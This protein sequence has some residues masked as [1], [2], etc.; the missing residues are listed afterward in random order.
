M[1]SN[2]VFFTKIE[3][4]NIFH[5]NLAGN[6]YR[7]RR[8]Q[9]LYQRSFHAVL[10]MSVLRKKTEFYKGA[11]YCEVVVIAA[12]GLWEGA[13]PAGRFSHY[14]TL[15][16]HQIFSSPPESLSSPYCYLKWDTKW[17]NSQGD[18]KKTFCLLGVFLWEFAIQK[19]LIPSLQQISRGMSPIYWTNLAGPGKSL[20]W[21]SGFGLGFGS[22]VF[23]AIKWVTMALKTIFMT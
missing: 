6:D 8:Y 9:V 22:N 15:P 4:H 17:I 1:S 19:L 11:S 5:D 13:S 23:K 20:G 10:I 21:V 18:V 12:R 14:G 16:S 7:S 2:R 3:D